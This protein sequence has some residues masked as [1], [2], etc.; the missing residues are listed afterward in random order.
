MDDIVAQAMARWPDV[1]A[2]Y[3]WL[4]LDKRGRWLVKG[5]PIGHRPTIAFINRNYHR[6]ARGRYY[7]QNGP[8]RV[9]VDL[10]HCPFVLSLTP[11]RLTS[12]PLAPARP[13]LPASASL[14]THLGEPVTAARRGWVDAQA[15][16]L[17]EFEHGVGSMLDRDLPALVECFLDGCGGRLNEQGWADALAGSGAD[18]TLALDCGLIP[19]ATLPH[20][21]GA[22]PFDFIDRPRPDADEDA[23]T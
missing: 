19:M 17:I 8:Q 11:T 18:L 22:A 14:V 9:F 21:A 1:P 5:E 20:A 15:G 10:E 16:V 3:G 13:G 23:C 2:V 12:A 7:F 6:D 4:R